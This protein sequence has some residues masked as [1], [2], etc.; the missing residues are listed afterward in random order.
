MKPCR[1]ARSGIEIESYVKFISNIVCIVKMSNC[2]TDLLDYDLVKKCCRCK[3]ILL[4]S[5]FHKDN[6]RKDGSFN[7]CKI[8]RKEYYIKNSIILIQKQKD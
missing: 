4:K 7:Q 8:C 1:Y 6:K 5:N 3:N 2:I